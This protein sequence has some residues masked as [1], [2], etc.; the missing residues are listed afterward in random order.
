MRK[1]ALILALCLVATSL[2]MGFAE[3]LIAEEELLEED[4]VEEAPPE[5][6]G[7]IGVEGL[8]AEPEGDDIE[9]DDSEY[10]DPEGD[11]PEDAYDLEQYEQGEGVDAD[12]LPEEDQGETAVEAPEEDG[13]AEEPDEASPHADPDGPRLAAD[14]LTLGEGET[15]ALKGKLPSGK[16]GNISYASSDTAVASVSADGTVTAVAP[17]DVTVT[18]ACEDGTWAECFV[19]VKKAPDAVSFSVGRFTI[20]KGE[21]VAAPS[22]VLGSKEGEFAGSYTIKSSKKKIV[23]V[24]ADGILR[25]IKKGKSTLT[26]TTYNGKVA[27][28]TVVVVNRPKKV[29]AKVDK[30]SMGLGETGRISYTLP[31]KSAGHVTYSSDDPDIVEVDAATGKMKAVGLGTTKV[32]V[33]TYNKKSSAVSVTVGNVPVTLTFPSD[34]FVMG[35]GMTV[36]SAAEVNEGAAAG[37]QYTVADP[38][39]ASFSSGEIKAKKQ[40]ETKL[41]ATTYN[42]L[43]ATCRLVVKPKPTKVTLPFKKLSIYKGDKVQ[44]EPSVGDSASTFR[45]SSSNTKKVKVS[46]DGV[47]TGVAKGSAYITIKTYNNKKFR[48]KVTVKR[49]ILPPGNPDSELPVNLEGMCL[50]IPARTTD[51]AGIPGNLAKIEA[52]RKSAIKQIDAMQDAGIITAADADKRKKIVNNAFTDYAFPWMTPSKQKYWKKANSEG[53]AKDF[54]P[55]LVYYGMPYISGSGYN[56]QYNVAR[57]LKEKRYTNSGEGYFLLNRKNLLNNRYCGNDCSGFVDAC[58]WGTG[59]AH[60]GDRTTEIAKSGDYRTIKEMGALRTGDLICKSAAHVVMFLYWASEDKTK[61]M[62]IE[63]GGIE[64]GTNTVHCIIMNSSFYQARGYKVRRLASLGK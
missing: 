49:K 33:T 3:E 56:R 45:Y 64:K 36:S 7:D 60:S 29:S 2:P 53:G 1:L 18:A 16:T 26:V 54:K 31:K 34:E 15:F 39:I 25:G 42:G 28:C 20:G 17:G 12:M 8:F 37:I 5:A 30:P 21:R 61:M 9:F 41:T 62:I 44:L 23:T 24:G 22:V 11:A 50:E 38:A 14:R 13:Q 32:R 63:N 59:K 43:T 4:F 47:V 48:L 58:I 52:I 6:V 35:E 46:K 55:G 10:D 40:G 27:K 51:I 19:T 57:A